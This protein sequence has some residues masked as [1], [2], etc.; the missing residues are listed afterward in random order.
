MGWLSSKFGWRDIAGVVVMLAALW[1]TAEYVVWQ[2][3]QPTETYKSIDL[4]E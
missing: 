2:E 1:A 3:E 4:G